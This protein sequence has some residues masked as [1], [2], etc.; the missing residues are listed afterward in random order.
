[1]TSVFYRNR[2]E[3]FFERDWEGN[4][5][6]VGKRCDDGCPS[7]GDVYRYDLIMIHIDGV[8]SAVQRVA[9]E[10]VNEGGSEHIRG[11]IARHLYPVRY[12][13]HR[14]DAELQR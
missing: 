14:P 8:A 3:R 11:R 12:L 13:R 4:G 9:R 6:R 7:G 5:A 2:R 1:M 10:I